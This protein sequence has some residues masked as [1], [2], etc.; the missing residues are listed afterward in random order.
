MAFMFW[1]V[2]LALVIVLA[3]PPAVRDRSWTVFLIAAGKA[4]MFVVL[5]AL[6]FLASALFQPEW[7]GACRYGWMDCFHGGKF[8]LAPLVLWATAAL[9]ALEIWR[10]KWPPHWWVVLG[11]YT[12]A[13]VA[14]ACLIHGAATVWDKGRV[15]IGLAIPLYVGVW[16][17]VRAAQLFGAARL[18]LWAYVGGWLGAVPFWVGSVLLSRRQY[19]ALPD[20]P[21]SCFVVT[22]ASRGH[23]SLVGPFVTVVRGGR[24]RRANAQLLTLWRLEDL[25]QRVCPRGHA[26]FR[27]VYNVCGPRAAALLRSPWAADLAY[28]A[29]KPAEWLARALVGNQQR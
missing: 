25:W 15:A 21:P 23:E 4:F 5:P 28:L 2:P 11:V 18:S 1:A 14:V 3:V 26:A 19:L 10:V 12:G 29:L 13:V 27:R 22:A 6:T 7:K 17:A 20:E 24:L 9:Y 16:Y 8:A